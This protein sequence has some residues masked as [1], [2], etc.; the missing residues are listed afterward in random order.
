MNRTLGIQAAL[1]ENE[2]IDRHRSHLVRAMGVHHPGQLLPVARPLH[3]PEGKVRS[4][5]SVVHLD[6][7]FQG[8]PGQA[9]LHPD[10]EIRVPRDPGPYHPGSATPA[11]R[12]QT[13]D[14]QLEPPGGRNHVIH[15]SSQ[16]VRG[17][18]FD[19]TKKDEGEMHMVGAYP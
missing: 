13:L 4:I 14:L 2:A 10:K 3:P 8:G 11:E 5:R 15:G 19:I 16:A 18:L 17:R 12:A 1:H 7:L 6:L 9:G